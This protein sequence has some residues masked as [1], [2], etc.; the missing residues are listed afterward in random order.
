MVIYNVLV[1]IN[2][3]RYSKKAQLFILKIQKIA[4]YKTQKHVKIVF[5]IIHFQYLLDEFKLSEVMANDGWW[6]NKL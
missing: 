1:L 2:V 4:F 5:C 6:A 3:A